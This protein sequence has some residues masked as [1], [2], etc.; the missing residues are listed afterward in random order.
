MFRRNLQRKSWQTDHRKMPFRSAWHDG[1]K[2]P[3]ERYGSMKRKVPGDMEPRNYRPA[4][5]WRAKFHCDRELI[6]ASGAAKTAPVC[7]C[8]ARE[9]STMTGSLEQLQITFPSIPTPE[10]SEPPPAAHLFCG[11]FFC[12][13][14]MWAATSNYSVIQTRLIRHSFGRR[15][16]AS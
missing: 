12:Q 14:S 2:V 8:A 15:A 11:A 9:R 16:D 4:R 3:V 13:R 5:G 1:T 7:R 10:R 6:A